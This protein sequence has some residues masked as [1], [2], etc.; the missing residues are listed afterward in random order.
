MEENIALMRRRRR[1]SGF[2]NSPTT[3]FA[4]KALLGIAVVLVILT[5]IQCSI[6]KPV[7]PIFTTNMTVPLI[8]RVYSIRE[9]IDKIDQPGLSID[10]TGDVLFSVNEEL[11]TIK[12]SDNLDINDISLEVS[13]TV[14]QV[15]LA[16][17]APGPVTIN[18]G[19]YISLNLGALQPVSFD[20]QSGFQ[21]FDNFNW[22]EIASG[23]IDFIIA[24]DFGVD[25]DT[26]ILQVFDVGYSRVIST[27][28][29]PSGIPAGGNDTA[30]V[31]LGG[32][33]I[34]NHLQLN[35]HCHTPGGEVLSLADKTMTTS[36]EFPGGLVIA[37]AQAVIPAV[38]KNFASEIQL[39]E[40][41]T[42]ISAEISSGTAEIQIHNFTSLQGNILISL[43]DFRINGLPYTL[44]RMVNPNSTDSVNINLDGFVFE[45]I[46]QS[47]PQTVEI[48]AR[49]LLDSTGSDL[50]T[51]QQ[52]DSISVKVSLTGLKFQGL[53]GIIDS[54]SASFDSVSAAIDLPKGFD[55]LQLVNAELILEVENGINFA[56][57]LNIDIIGNQG[58][59]LTLQG[60]IAAGNPNSPVISYISNSN[61]ADFLNP[62]PSGITVSGAIQFGDG[63]SSGTI[64]A[65]DFIVSR[66]K[67]SSPLEAVIGQS[68]FE[69]SIASEK[70]SQ[71]DIDKIMDHIVQADFN[72]T[73]TNHLP[74]GVSVEIY[75]SGDSA[76]V[77]TNP[78]L[79]LGPIEVNAGTIESNGEVIF[80][81]ESENVISI[82]SNDIKI[83]ENPIL[84]SGQIITLVGSNGQTIKITSDDYVAASGVI[85]VQYKFNGKF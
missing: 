77:Y 9:I 53:T 56:G 10:S 55:S 54:T 57:N 80:S 78:E 15:S 13:E 61:L 44:S 34:S 3:H 25:L 38:E 36:L 66:V 29:L 60:V 4:L 67:I 46:D 16:P 17:E 84:Y 41:N 47:K 45:P 6:E 8:N 76:T 31:N 74:L 7:A 42:I 35:I 79:T 30:H 12:V 33:T 20:V 65:D 40:S 23:G 73:I 39:S 11:D 82:D 2:L 69:G 24:N 32:K 71:E 63:I 22:A 14:G 58:K 59:A 43:P 50:V 5:L 28:P 62:V 72:S 18:L 27:T 26:V 81:T 68:V 21:A 52:S 75:F 70:I 64:S 51:I 1:D 48:Q 49:A 19:D 37:A 83:L 85:Q